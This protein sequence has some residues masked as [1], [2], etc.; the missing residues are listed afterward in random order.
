MSCGLKEPNTLE[1][2]ISNCLSAT[3][4]FHYKCIIP[5]SKCTDR[6]TQLDDK[7]T[8]IASASYIRNFLILVHLLL[9]FH[10]IKSVQTVM[11]VIWYAWMQKAVNQW[12]VMRNVILLVC[13][14]VL[15]VHFND[16]Q[17]RFFFNLMLSF[18]WYPT[19][20]S[21]YV[22]TEKRI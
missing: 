2:N 1:A 12:K 15:E 9:T 20:N 11:C 6:G 5:S 22:A 13:S 4:I 19:W 14:Q 3:R 21:K 8:K 7:T 10:T 18:E 16:W 17:I